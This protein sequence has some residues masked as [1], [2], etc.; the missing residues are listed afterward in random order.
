MC[1]LWGY[2]AVE[3]VCIVVVD[4]GD[5][6]DDDS[7]FFCW[8]RTKQISHETQ[9]CMWARGG[10]YASVVVDSWATWMAT[11]RSWALT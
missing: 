8:A 1:D 9:T 10:W 5:D 6:G 2:K 11:R 4:G 3:L 7:G